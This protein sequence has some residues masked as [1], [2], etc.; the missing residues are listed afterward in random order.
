MLQSVLMGLGQMCM[1]LSRVD[2]TLPEPKMTSPPIY[3]NSPPSLTNQ[4]PTGSSKFET[5]TGN[6]NGEDHGDIT[7]SPLNQDGHTESHVTRKTHDE[8]ANAG[9]FPLWMI[10]TMVGAC[11]ALLLCVLQT[12]CLIMRCRKKKSVDLEREPQKLPVPHGPPATPN[13]YAASPCVPPPAYVTTAVK[14]TL[15]GEQE[16]ELDDKF[17]I[18]EDDVMEKPKEE[19]K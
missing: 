13:I 17:Q 14:Q 9:T 7:A 16:E 6:H 4:A 8:V 1:R 15:G 10:L 5:T 19:E 3:P 12:V 11:A 18:P 2:P